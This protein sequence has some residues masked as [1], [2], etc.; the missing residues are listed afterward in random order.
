LLARCV[1]QPIEE[2]SRIF[3]SQAANDKKDKASA[4]KASKVLTTLLH[5][6]SLLAV[7]L[8]CICP[9]Y[10]P[11]LVR[12]LLGSRWSN[13]SAPAI[14]RLYCYLLPFLGFNGILEAFVQ[15]TV[16]QRQIS[17]MNWWMGLWSFVYVAA[18]IF[19]CQTLQLQSK[20]LIYANMVNMTCRIA[21]CFS[22]Y[23]TWLASNQMDVKFRSV[24]P[25]RA[26]LLFSGAAALLV[27]WSEPDRFAF[28]S[29]VQ[30]IGV[31]LTAML[32]CIII[33]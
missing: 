23:R 32:A 16:D 3:F 33:A 17:R 19:F 14:L 10:V 15:S 24:L 6:Y 29:T 7:L 28:K 5:A 30:H 9:P 27:R 20:G 13:T 18:C 26:L 8:V 21:W 1:F 12:L 4:Q 22:Y 31:G 11:T 25:S 2:S